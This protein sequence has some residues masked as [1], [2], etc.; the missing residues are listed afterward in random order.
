MSAAESPRPCWGGGGLRSLSRYYPDSGEVMIKRGGK[1]NAM[2]VR[3]IAPNG[4]P[5]RA[6]CHLQAEGESQC[7]A[8]HGRGGEPARGVEQRRIR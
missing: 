7:S 2:S 8:D 5:F 1:K 4:P 6:V 3:T